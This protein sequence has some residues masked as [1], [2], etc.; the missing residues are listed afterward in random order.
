MAEKPERSVERIS[1]VSERV[2][3]PMPS[4]SGMRPAVRVT[5]NSLTACFFGRGEGRSLA[6][7]AKHYDIVGMSLHDVVENASERFEIN[8]FVGGEGS[9][10][11]HSQT[12]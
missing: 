5:A 8:L 3:F 12:G 1:S 7:G 2:Q 11:G 6:C 4:T 10:G 9:D